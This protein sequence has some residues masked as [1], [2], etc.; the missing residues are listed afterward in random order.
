MTLAWRRWGI[1]IV[2]TAPI[3]ILLAA[4]PVFRQ[5]GNL[6]KCPLNLLV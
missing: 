5:P 3:A 2:L 1:F 6:F 4:N